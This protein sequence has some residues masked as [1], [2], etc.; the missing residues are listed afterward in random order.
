MSVF[1]RIEI[2]GGFRLTVAGRV[3]TSLPQK[4]KALLAYLAMQDG[5]PVSRETAADLLWTDRGATQA[6]NSLKQTL[7]VLR[8]DMA[9]V[10]LSNQPV[11]TF[12]PGTVETDIGRFRRLSRSSDRADLVE[13][14]EAYRGE[15]LEGISTVSSDFDDWLRSARTEVAD[16]A[17]ETYRRFVDACLRKL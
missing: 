8:R 17:I 1:V 3:V 16:Q 12:V 11:L 13:A 7:L 2:L 6:R 5:R 4:A 9:D 14:A 10:I 15:L